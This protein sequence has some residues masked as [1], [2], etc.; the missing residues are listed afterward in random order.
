MKTIVLTKITYFHLCA[1]QQCI[2]KEKC[3]YSY[4]MLT[5]AAGFIDITSIMQLS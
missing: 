4:V 3:N 1:Q 5:N 2:T